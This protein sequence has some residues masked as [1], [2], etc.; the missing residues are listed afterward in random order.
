MGTK[1]VSFGQM[2]VFFLFVGL[3]FFVVKKL[4]VLKSW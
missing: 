3:Y 4:L 1:F 2:N